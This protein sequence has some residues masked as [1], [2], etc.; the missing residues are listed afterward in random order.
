MNDSAGGCEWL[1]TWVVPLCG[2]WYLSHRYIFIH[3]VCVNH[4]KLLAIICHGRNEC[5]EPCV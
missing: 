1:Q 5:Q 3:A 2:G 4:A